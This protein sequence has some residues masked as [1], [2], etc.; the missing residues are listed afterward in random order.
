MI[1]LD[2]TDR[3]VATCRVLINPFW[4]HFQQC[5]IMNSDNAIRVFS[6]FKKYLFELLYNKIYSDFLC[7]ISK[8]GWYLSRLK[9]IASILLTGYRFKRLLRY[10]LNRHFLL[11]I[12]QS[13]K[14]TIF[15]WSIGYRQKNFEN[16]IKIWILIGQ[17]WSIAM[18]QR[19][20]SG[21]GFVL[22]R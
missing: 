19:V 15:I 18:K 3:N 16:F 1:H 8:F 7:F 17:R 14:N 21:E 10:A 12:Q 11:C 13:V 5:H 6:L 20:K 22:V 4:F 9:H 2:L